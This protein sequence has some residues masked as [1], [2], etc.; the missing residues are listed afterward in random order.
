MVD[1]VVSFALNRITDFLIQEAAFLG[2]VRKEVQWLKDELGWM[3]CYIASAEEKQNDVPMVRKWLN[4]VT[5]IAYDVEDV[6]DKFI[7]QVHDEETD[8]DQYT[9]K[10]TKPTGCF[11]SMSSCI[12][13]KKKVN[14]PEKVVKLH[15]IGNDIEELKNRIND[16]LESSSNK[17]EGKSNS[18]ARLRQ[19]RRTTSFSIEEKVVGHEDGTG[20]MK[21]SDLVLH[22]KY[23]NVGVVR[24]FFRKN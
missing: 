8:H 5:K 13:C 3:Q 16:Q 19:L 23:E 18:L 7:L 2:R 14:P 24:F 11:P 17:W 9:N 4:D 15:D 20:V 10:E 22:I 1:A 12:K 6:I 21:L